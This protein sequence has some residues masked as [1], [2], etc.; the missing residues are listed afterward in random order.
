MDIKTEKKN[1]TVTLRLQGQL[2]IYSARIFYTAVIGS[3]E[4]ATV[5]E[6]DLS[7]ISD[8]DSAGVQ[9]LMALKRKAVALKKELRLLKHS[10]V[11]LSVFD[12]YGLAG[13][14]ADRIS[15]PREVRKNYSFAYGRK[16][17]NHKGP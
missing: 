4:Q 7:G 10:P 9:I 8:I 2:T 3:L 6:I 16:P 13:F 1:E 17:I 11:V 14:F 5:L 12:L 15:I